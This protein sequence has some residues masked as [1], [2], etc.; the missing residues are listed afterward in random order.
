MASN[1]DRA[2][3]VNTNP[4]ENTIL[5]FTNGRGE[6]RAINV[7]RCIDELG[8]IPSL[9]AISLDE[10]D[11][12][13]F[14]FACP[15]VHLLPI[16]FEFDFDPDKSS[17]NFE[18]T[19]GFQ[20][21][22]QVVYK[23]GSTSAI[24]PYSD[25]AYP[26]AI[27]N[28]GL[29]TL[30]ETEVENRCVLFIPKLSAEA[31]LIRLISREGNNDNPRVIDQFRVDVQSNDFIITDDDF[32]GQYSFYNDK[33]G[34]LLSEIDATKTFDNV[35]RN[36]KAQTVADNRVMY[37]NYTEGYANIT[38]DVNLSVE[39]KQAPPPGFSFELKAVPYVFRKKTDKASGEAGSAD[40]GRQRFKTNS[41][42]VLDT[43]GF[44]E[45]VPV[46]VYTVSITIAPKNNYHIFLG[47]GESPNSR[48]NP[49]V[50][51]GPTALSDF[52]FN[53]STS[54]L[55]GSSAA[56]SKVIRGREMGAASQS[57]T[58]GLP[59]DGALRASYF[60]GGYN[61]ASSVTWD[62]S[63][64]DLHLTDIGRSFSSPLVF[65]GEPVTFSTTIQVNSSTE[66]D[67]FSKALI[68]G[69]C[70]L[71]PNSSP[72]DVFGSQVAPT[73]SPA[74]YFKEVAYDLGLNDDSTFSAEGSFLS[75]LVC[76]VSSGYNN[77]D[78]SGDMCSRE[79][80][81]F[82]VINKATMR[83]CGEPARGYAGQID[84][85][86][87][88]YDQDKSG[89]G[90]FMSFAHAKDV[91]VKTVVPLPEGKFGSASSPGA[92][93]QSFELFT[94]N[95]NGSNDDVVR[96]RRF[97]AMGTGDWDYRV[98]SNGNNQ[99]MWPSCYRQWQTPDGALNGP[100]RIQNTNPEDLQ[101]Y[102]ESA[103]IDQG[104]VALSSSQPDPMPAPVL[105]TRQYDDG[106]IF[107]SND[108]FRN[109]LYH[110]APIKKWIIAG[111]EN[112]EVLPSDKSDSYWNTIHGGAGFTVNIDVPNDSFDNAFQDAGQFFVAGNPSTMLGDISKHYC[113]YLKNYNNAGYFQFGRDIEYTAPPDTVNVSNYLDR[114]TLSLVD[115]EMG[116]GGMNGLAAS[117]FGNR[118]DNSSFGLPFV[119]GT[120]DINGDTSSNVMGSMA[121]IRGTVTNFGLLGYVDNCPGYLV[122][123]IVAR[124][125]ETVNSNYNGA[126][127][128]GNS[129]GSSQL[130]QSFAVVVPQ[131]ADV[132]FALN[133]VL[134]GEAQ[135]LGVVF[136]SPLT[137]GYFSSFYSDP[138]ALVSCIDTRDTA[139]MAGT[140][141]QGNYLST[142]QPV[143]T[144]Q[145]PAGSTGSAIVV[146]GASINTS[147]EELGYNSFK[148]KANHEFGI[149]YYD[150]RGRHGAVQ[151]VGSVYVPGYDTEDRGS[152]L[153]G[154]A[155][156]KM[157]INHAPPSW[158]TEYRVVYS[159][160]T[161][162]SEFIQHTVADAFV[163]SKAP[164]RIY[165]SLNHL[166][167]NKISYAESYGA[168]SLDDGT[169]SLYRFNQGDRLRIIN[170]S[171]VSAELEYAPK[172]YD[173]RIVDLEIVGPDMDNHPFPNESDQARFNGEFLVLEDNKEA[174]GFRVE[175]ILADT[176]G[177]V[178]SF[179]GN[180]CLV[181]IYRPSKGLG[182]ESRPYFELNYGGKILSGP[183][184]Q[185]NT[186]L[187]TKGDVFYRSVPMN[188]QTITSDASTEQTIGE[189]T[190]LIQGSTDNETSVPNPVSYYVES[191]TVT[192]LYKSDAK[193]YGRVHFV[194][195]FADE[196]ERPSS[197]SFSE[198]TFQGSYNL[199]Y[200][201]FPKIGNF[202]D[203]PRY[204]GGIDV[205]D[206][207]GTNIMSFNDS[208][209][210]YI[211]VSR[212]V[213][214]TGNTDAIVASTKVLGSEIAIP[215]D[216]GSS[217]RPESVI[218]INNDFFFFD[219]RN[220]R[221]VMIKGGRTPVIVTDANVDAYFKSEVQK[222]KQSGAFKAPSGYDPMRSE[223][224]ISLSSLE[225]GYIYH[226]HVS[227]R[228]RMLTMGFDLKT[229]KFWK[230]RYSFAP[231][232][233]STLNGKLISYHSEKTLTHPNTVGD[234][235]ESP[236]VLPQI[237]NDTSK[238]NKIYGK[239]VRSSLCVSANANNSK[240]KEFNVVVLD[241]DNRWEANLYTPTGASAIPFGRFKGYND[242]YYGKIVGD[243][244]VAAEQRKSQITKRTI[245]TMPYAFD[246]R[247]I[248]STGQLLQSQ[249]LGPRGFTFVD[250]NGEIYG[251]NSTGIKYME[252]QVVMSKSSSAFTAPL[253]IGKNSILY[254]S[255]PGG[256]QMVPLGSGPKNTHSFNR[257]AFIAADTEDTNR[258]RKL[259]IRA[260]WNQVENYC[261]QNGHEDVIERVTTDEF[262]S[263]P[264]V[265][266][267]FFTSVNNDET[268]YK[269]F[270]IIFAPYYSMFFGK[271]VQQ[272]GSLNNLISLFD[273]E[274]I[275]SGGDQAE[276]VWDLNEDG[277]VNVSDLLIF[278]TG[279]GEPFGTEDLLGLLAEFGSGVEDESTVDFDTIGSF[280]AAQFLNLYNGERKEIH[281]VY[282][283]QL[284]APELTGRYMKIDLVSD[285]AQDDAQLYEI[286]VDHDNRVKSLSR[287]T[288]SKKK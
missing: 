1:T 51:A 245:Q 276:Y 283:N 116:P 163:S 15:R 123:E 75:D 79:P 181:E 12:N 221:I 247:L 6:P 176:S 259:V 14:K 224:L 150:E 21:S 18:N 197:I 66:R 24:A 19:D 231:H 222:W 179:W 217:K 173:F 148:T 190:S 32:L 110:P 158:A 39:F 72:I 132:G 227:A 156:V 83:F 50:G 253:A 63:N 261:L 152:S 154:A 81:G 216:G 170:Y 188:A 206:F 113:G 17:G 277:L 28:L 171:N 268:G 165:V 131:Y 226:D 220:E 129:S 97:F 49:I 194:D 180:R 240:T 22:Y 108:S 160:N 43:S 198:K 232:F 124:T 246:E 212:D 282:S 189:Y 133:D 225:D 285:D 11:Q 106:K 91:N 143:Q 82:F 45:S 67:V 239:K 139:D 209:V 62:S 130:A 178:T 278:L 184:H 3:F 279:F 196:V 151:P 76:S 13:D 58:A 281:S 183:T 126:F 69:L 7:E 26:P 159:G 242:K 254:E 205:M 138:G 236:F 80:D 185:F 164:G 208:K 215:I 44:P 36:A 10:T 121:N 70:G 35:P 64:G 61:T 65:K 172:D 233:Y 101:T 103:T 111:D 107:E 59:V 92:A 127:V 140:I 60:N 114:G 118:S 168:V 137:S 134:L 89:Y 87:Y 68:H 27:I 34:A 99:I 255:S 162:V 218:S 142:I 193:N 37:G 8:Q 2:K 287:G 31:K 192:D 38:T 102:L 120:H 210:Y 204:S 98:D 241:S 264:S 147:S 200:F 136:R 228:D 119:M 9:N 90:M 73:S 252:F 153:K 203:L 235:I 77:S 30:A 238:R 175:D 262:T 135:P 288:K 266:F 29:K 274:G 199:R 105:P 195:R 78:V 84:D 85:L 211:P 52:I 55:A 41:G 5:A 275:F 265:V 57:D 244:T 144:R 104:T 115:G 248:P 141:A 270:D 284:N 48:E 202:K 234:E 214:T 169:K 258:T 267:G 149:V 191:E 286:M 161:S 155:K 263:N 109:T 100:S 95:I 145:P 46:G 54:A 25:V 93:A 273:G 257:K 280:T 207:Q 33:I 272:D 4:K 112:S 157:E 74:N 122:S 269:I 42:F 94:N 71:H 271:S 249:F 167:S 47:T 86:L 256:S 223:Y 174:S 117:Q 23:N 177:N 250:E 251:V 229:N 128:L 187:M 96:A 166:Q 230:S 125:P 20:F 237:H 186:I 260:P 56:P 182:D 53:Q 219:E 146:S 213:L 243:T 40:L 201:S 88:E 16:S